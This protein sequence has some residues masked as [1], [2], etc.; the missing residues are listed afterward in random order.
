MSRLLFSAGIENSC[1]GSGG[2]KLNLV[3]ALF[4]R[5][6]FEN[7]AVLVTSGEIE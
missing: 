3:I 4:G 2:R 5:G 7:L 6:N 1:P